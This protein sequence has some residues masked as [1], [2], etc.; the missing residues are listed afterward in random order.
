MVRMKAIL[1]AADMFPKEEFASL[2][3]M[4][5][6]RAY[7]QVREINRSTFIK[8]R[9]SIVKSLQFNDKKRVITFAYHLKDAENLKRQLNYMFSPIEFSITSLKKELSTEE[10]LLRLDKAE[11]SSD[12]SQVSSAA[13]EIGK[14][15]SD[16]PDV[17][18]II[19]NLREVIEKAA[20]KPQTR[21]EYK[22]LL[23][24]K[25]LNC[26]RQSDL[27]N[28][29]PKTFEIIQNSYV[30]RMLRVLVTE[31]KNSKPRYIYFFPVLGA[32]N[33]PLLALDELFRTVSPVS[34]ISDDK[35]NNHPEASVAP[36]LFGK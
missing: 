13:D 17:W 35:P 16:N 24:L 2:L 14:L 11:E 21:A 32:T 20:A 30:G 36:R 5:I 23:L 10:I 18:S 25:F 27:K 1:D 26:C 34:Q 3:A 28:A 22:F 31:T 4:L 29:D 9:M 8:Y 19:S 15:L 7:S 33:D 12:V 6:I